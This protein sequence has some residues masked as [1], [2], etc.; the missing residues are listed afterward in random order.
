MPSTA[1]TPLGAGSLA[2]RWW[3]DVNTGTHAAPTWVAVNG[4]EDFKAPLDA[5][6]QDDSD[7]DSGGYKSSTVTALGWK[8]DLKLARKTTVASATVYDPGAEVLRAASELMGASNRVEVRWYEMTTGGPKVEAYQGY[9]AVSWSED[10]GGMDALA[11]VS[12]T[13]TGQGSRDE[14]T[15]PDGAAVA[16]V[17]YSITPAVGGTAGGSMHV[18]RGA[19]FMLAGVDN[20]KATSGVLF[21][22]TNATSWVTLSDDEIVVVAPA[23]VAGPF[24]VYVENA[25]GKSV[26]AT[27]TYTAS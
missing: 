6:V 25:V 18:I 27:V 5:S 19:G 3:L 20:V 12:V 26:T 14:I 22:V 1:R 17:L 9:A 23:K 15:H 4:V 16:P 24:V 10:G 21:G 7:Y 2:R 11:S 8:I 13:L